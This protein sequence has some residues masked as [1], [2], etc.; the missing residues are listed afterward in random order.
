MAEFPSDPTRAVPVTRERGASE[1]RQGA[2]PGVERKALRG[3][4]KSAAVPMCSHSYTGPR[5][6]PR[7]T[8]MRGCDRPPRETPVGLR[9]IQRIMD[10]FPTSE[11]LTAALQ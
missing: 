1:L 6:R 2:A 10:Y 4:D 3:V 5:G 8:A 11:G 7:P 9:N